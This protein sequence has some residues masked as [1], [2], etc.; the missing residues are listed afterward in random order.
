MSF[1]KSKVHKTVCGQPLVTTLP[2]GAILTQF[3]IIKKS[4]GEHAVHTDM[5]GIQWK[6]NKKVEVA[7]PTVE[8][9]YYCPADGVKMN[10]FG[11]AYF[12]PK[13]STIRRKEE[14]VTQ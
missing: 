10:T 9:S 11:K 5:N 14:A 3:C 4:A 7:A 13:C 8:V 2:T 1:I 6:E 12:C